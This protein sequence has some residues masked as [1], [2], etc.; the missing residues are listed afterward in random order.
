MSYL[1]YGELTGA[2]YDEVIADL[3]KTAEVIERDGWTKGLFHE[4][5]DL[6]AERP[7]H[8]VQGAIATAI[9]DDPWAEPDGEWPMM[10]R[11]VR[12]NFAL[13]QLVGYSTAEWNDEDERTAED[14]I[15]TL[16]ETI[17]RLQAEKLER[18]S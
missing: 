9:G 14:V 1:Y 5:R 4:L 7:C 6:E 8:C 15:D 11:W 3:T 17:E 2:E 13:T 10:P 16:R 18:T 12:A